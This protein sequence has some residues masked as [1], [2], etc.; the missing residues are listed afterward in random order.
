MIDDVED[1][2]EEGT[3]VEPDEGPVPQDP[4]DLDGF[5][6]LVAEY[7]H[8]I[9]PLEDILAYAEGEGIP[10]TI[11]E[12]LELAVRAEAE[13]RVTLWEG[14]GV[15]CVTLD[16][17]EARRMGL[18]LSH[19]SERWEP[20]GAPL[21]RAHAKDTP[22][23]DGSRTIPLPGYEDGHPGGGYTPGDEHRPGKRWVAADGSMWIDPAQPE[24]IDVMTRE[25]GV[26]LRDNR[27]VPVYLVLGLGVPWPQG[28]TPALV[29]E[30]T[31]DGVLLREVCR[32]CKRPDA[33]R[34]PYNAYCAICDRSGIDHRLPAVE[35]ALRQG[36]RK[37]HDPGGLGGGTGDPSRT[38]NRGRQRSA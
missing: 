16:A 12:I 10:N 17:E 28:R 29:P 31:D 6:W 32:G 20:A 14:E 8:A 22:N 25:E 18:R 9:A 34:L 4:I 1:I 37:R 30:A 23:P 33:L 2:P 21:P 19:L 35:P 24:P 15:P 5:C 11:E 13:R 26:E 38:K 27:M 7:G 3:A 36:G